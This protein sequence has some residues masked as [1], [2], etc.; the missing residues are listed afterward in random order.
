MKYPV[1]IQNLLRNKQI[2]KIIQNKTWRHW[3]V[4]GLF[5]IAALSQITFQFAFPV[6]ITERILILTQA[7]SCTVA[8]FS[9]FV[10]ELIFLIPL[11]AGVLIPQE[12]SM[13]F[14][15]EITVFMVIHC[16]K[17]QK[18]WRSVLYGVYVSMLNGLG[19]S[20]F[21]DPDT[22]LAIAFFYIV[23]LL[24]GLW[25]RAESQ[26]QATLSELKFSKFRENV[27][28]EIHDI[29]GN[30][31]LQV[32]L[33]AQANTNAMPKDI[34]KALIN[35]ATISREG[36]EEV[37]RMSLQIRNISNH[38]NNETLSETRISHICN[39]FVKQI[40]RI[41]FEVDFNHNDN[42]ARIPTHLAKTISGILRESATNIMKYADSEYPVVFVCRSTNRDVKLFIG[43]GVLPQNNNR[44]IVSSNQG[45]VSIKNRVKSVGGIVHINTD[46]ETWTM[47]ISV[48]LIASDREICTT[49]EHAHKTFP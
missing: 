25:F 43:N 49:N 22:V 35:I 16:A 7:L 4:I 47:T 11:T 19:F 38:V 33:L 40:T 27:A 14:F 26:T 34:S 45:L 44:N 9:P 41:G 20:S 3:L 15:A 42:T 29:L 10:G 24:I 31:L 30:S 18:P 37:R 2:S 39:S 6:T 32:S 8:V 28:Q 12:V 36:L 48:P 17:T 23:F 1:S 5:S 13:G 21:E 46:G